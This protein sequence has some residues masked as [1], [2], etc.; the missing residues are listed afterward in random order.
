MTNAITI[1]GTA[2]T[3]NHGIGSALCCVAVVGRDVRARHERH[4][5][6]LLRLHKP[7]K[8][9]DSSSPAASTSFTAP[10]V[11]MPATAWQRPCQAA[12]RPAVA[13]DMYLPPAAW[14]SLVIARAVSA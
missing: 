2:Q 12:P 13:V 11:T 8:R 14:A 4:E 1:N 10:A 7:G 9:L 3:R 5:R 6:D